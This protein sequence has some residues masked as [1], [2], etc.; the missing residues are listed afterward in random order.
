[1]RVLKDQ[2][3]RNNLANNS[4]EDAHLYNW[5]YY[6]EYALR[7]NTSIKN[8]KARLGDSATTAPAA[9][10]AASVDR[11]LNIEFLDELCCEY[12]GN[13]DSGISKLLC[14]YMLII[15]DG[16]TLSQ[17]YVTNLE[18]LHETI[19]LMKT[20]GEVSS[21]FIY[22]MQEH[23]KAVD[24]E[25]D[26]NPL[27]FTLQ[28]GEYGLSLDNE[29]TYNKNKVLR[30]LNTIRAEKGLTPLNNLD[31]SIQHLNEMRGT[32]GLPPL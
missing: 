26:N 2:L 11:E 19:S 1:M 4:L 25:F 20:N 10:P 23:F 16:M 29:Y 7:V 13:L 15:K 21:D 27:T 5:T 17:D 6:N 3:I 8:L 18:F 24:L 12:Y 31:I 22:Q 30:D 28:L 32:E 14:T 9:A